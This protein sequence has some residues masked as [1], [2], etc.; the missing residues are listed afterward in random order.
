MQQNINIVNKKAK[1][2]YFL[3]KK[4]IAGLVLS[5]SEI[6][7]IR[8]KNVNLE[9]DVI[10][11]L[12]ENIF[13]SVRELEGALNKIMLYSDITKTELN[14]KNTQN[15]LSDYIEEV[16][17]IY[18]YNNIDDQDEILPVDYKKIDY[19]LPLRFIFTSDKSTKFFL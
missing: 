9:R 14:L 19:F 5:G 15:I 4:Y 13:S 8:L 18:G 11:F 10:T 16:A 2:K 6:K 17:R 12:A 1:F 7:S 3:N